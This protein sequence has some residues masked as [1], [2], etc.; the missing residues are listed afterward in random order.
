MSY[1]KKKISRIPQ[2]TDSKIFVLSK[3]LTNII[4]KIMNNYKKKSIFF[5]FAIVPPATSPCANN[6]CM[7]GGQCNSQSASPYYKCTCAGGFTGIH[8][9][10]KIILLPIELSL[11]M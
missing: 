8:C 6:P 5:F 3:N 4:Y 10:S 9:E 2:L 7:N 11:N 1:L